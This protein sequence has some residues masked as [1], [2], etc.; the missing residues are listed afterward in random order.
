MT[1]CLKNKKQKKVQK[2]N[3]NFFR[4]EIQERQKEFGDKRGFGK[5]TD[6]RAKL[7]ESQFRAES[8]IPLKKHKGL[9]GELD[10][11]RRKK[12]EKVDLIPGNVKAAIRVLNKEVNNDTNSPGAKKIKKDI[13]S[14]IWCMRNSLAQGDQLKKVERI[15]LADMVLQLKTMS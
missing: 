5:K 3:A 11:P 15:R 7:N 2:E 13:R 4:K 1:K 8:H 6:L 9:K 14:E 10:F 12:N